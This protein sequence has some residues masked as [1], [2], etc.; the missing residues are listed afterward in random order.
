MA[1]MEDEDRSKRTP[2]PVFSSVVEE[3][4]AWKWVHNDAI[5]ISVYGFVRAWGKYT[6]VFWSFRR[7]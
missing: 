5:R 6:S 3:R 7:R 4:R 2:G 1:E